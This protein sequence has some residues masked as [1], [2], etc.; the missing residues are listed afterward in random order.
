MHRPTKDP[1]TRP[2]IQTLERL[3]M[4]LGEKKTSFG[5]MRETGVRSIEIYC[6]ACGRRGAQV[7]PHFAPAPMG[8]GG[9][10]DVMGPR[11]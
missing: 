9:P 10:A 3:H 7:R 1:H 11:V 2:A 4:E 6:K 5:E 8:T